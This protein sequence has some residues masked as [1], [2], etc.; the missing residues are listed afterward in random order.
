MSVLGAIE[1]INQMYLVRF[2][3]TE[4][5]GCVYGMP[6]INA[7]C[8]RPTPPS[9]AKELTVCRSCGRWVSGTCCWFNSHN[10]LVRQA[11][12]CPVIFFVNGRKKSIQ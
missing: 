7:V 4:E 5:Q 3:Y 11:K 2:S 6:G 10:N 1:T 9:L 12:C 8:V